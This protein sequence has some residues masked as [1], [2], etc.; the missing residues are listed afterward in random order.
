[1]KLYSYGTAPN[2]LKVVIFLAEKGLDYEL[3]EV[4]MMKGEHK[5]PDFLKK[6]PSG[7]FWEEAEVHKV[8]EVPEVTEAPKEPPGVF[9]RGSPKS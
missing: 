5:T 9:Q 7:K 1:M 2:P 8:T 3:V 6:N 4:D